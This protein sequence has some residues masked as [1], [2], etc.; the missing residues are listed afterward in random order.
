MTE[1]FEELVRSAGRGIGAPA[2]IPTYHEA[3]RRGRRRWF[4]KRG[5]LAAAGA[6][7]L[8][9][10]FS[11][12]LGRLS[13]S[14]PE[15]V[16]DIATDMV[17]VPDNA[18]VPAPVFEPTPAEPIPTTAPLEAVP[19]LD[20][21]ASSEP[22]AAGDEDPPAR[23]APDGAAAD[24]DGAAVTPVATPLPDAESSASVAATP[25]AGP[26]TPSPT[27]ERAAIP[28]PTSPPDALPTAD[29]RAT[30][31]P[32]ATRE[33]VSVEVTP[34]ETTPPG[35]GAGTDREGATTNT[36]SE[37][38]DGVDTP[39]AIPEPPL[40]EVIG[41]SA[42]A[43]IKL[44][45]STVDGAR[46]CDTD[47]DGQADATCRLLIGYECKSVDQQREGFVATD[48]DADGLP[49]WCVADVATGCDLDGD[50]RADLAC[51][52]EPLERN[53]DELGP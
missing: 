9:L 51:V 27:P 14:D 30:P 52:I 53:V 48:L 7:A 25:P 21:E 12:D 26:A 31:E 38:G 20:I 36:D 40:A 22:V 16:A 19:D 10:A 29:P 3:W 5:A 15:D 50:G 47:G 24:D 8:V 49:D 4:V 42:A 45:S 11:A 39:T 17:G 2:E 46:P 23:T 37:G 33:P 43:T 28:A 18:E 1:E 6:L 13:G 35:A 32:D 41:T 34:A 44:P